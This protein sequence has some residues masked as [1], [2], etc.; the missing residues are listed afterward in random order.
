[1]RALEIRYRAEN[2]YG[3]RLIMHSVHLFPSNS[4]AGLQDL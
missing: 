2:T 4:L 3:F 1:L